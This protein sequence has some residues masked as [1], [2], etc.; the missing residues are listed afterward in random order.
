MTHVVIATSGISRL[1]LSQPLGG[2]GSPGQYFSNRLGL[3]NIGETS[4]DKTVVS[5][6]PLF[7][8][9]ACVTWFEKTSL[10]KYEYLEFRLLVCGM[11]IT[12]KSGQGDM[13]VLK[14][15]PARNHSLLHFYNDMV[16]TLKRSTVADKRSIQH[17]LQEIKI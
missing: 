3:T 4:F 5:K 1:I 17:R 14:A 16:N 10:I 9:A 8:Y 11:S 2:F 12:R 13:T 15:V 7:K 6:A